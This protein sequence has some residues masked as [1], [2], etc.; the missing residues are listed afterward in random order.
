[1]TMRTDFFFLL[2]AIKFTRTFGV[3]IAK[4][5]GNYHSDLLEPLSVHD[6]NSK[7]ELHITLS[8]RIQRDQNVHSQIESNANEHLNDTIFL[9]RLFRFLITSTILLDGRG[10]A[11]SHQIAWRT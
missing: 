6:E 3:K 4:A 2:D 1:M 8:V 10:N 11:V 9:L 7:S 5:E